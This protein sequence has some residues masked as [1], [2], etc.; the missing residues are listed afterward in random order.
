MEKLLWRGGTV[1]RAIGGTVARA[2]GGTVARAIGGTVA[3]AIGGTVAHV[4][5]GISSHACGTRRMYLVIH[6][7][8]L[9]LCEYLRNPEAIP[10][11]IV[12]YLGIFFILLVNLFAAC[13]ITR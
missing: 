8:S 6:W 3:R 10:C 2:I 13:S 9:Q 1:A 12:Q 5:G 7:E 4:I 11:G